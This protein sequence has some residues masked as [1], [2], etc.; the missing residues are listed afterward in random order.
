VP[1]IVDLCGTADDASSMYLVFA[2]CLGGDLYRRLSHRGLMAEGQL[3]REVIIPLLRVLAALHKLGIIHRC[4]RLLCAGRRTCARSCQTDARLGGAAAV[5][6]RARSHALQHAHARTHTNPRA[7]RDIKP[8]NIFFEACGRLV[9]GDFSLA[10]DAAAERPISRV[11]TQAYMAPEVGFDDV[12]GSWVVRV[13]SRRRWARQ[14]WPGPARTPTL[15]LACTPHPR[16]R[17]PTPPA[18]VRMHLLPPPHT[19][20]RAQ[21]LAQP[22]PDVVAQRCLRPSQ[23]PSYDH[24]CDIWGVGVL[25]YEALMGVTPFADADPTTAALKAQFRPPM[26][27]HSSATPACADFVS[28][29]LS[30][31]PGRRPSALQ[32]LSHEWVLAHMEQAQDAAWLAQPRGTPSAATAA[33]SG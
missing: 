8:E 32:L 1:G 3:C 33:A 26:P 25:V 15:C 11:G 20:T 27:L 17:A 23:L 29:A 9:L 30:K 14:H 21:V 13:G 10:I 24:K 12:T 19:H 4:V 6:V 2:P 31:H 22:S 16:W 5:T 18:H 7:R 28:R